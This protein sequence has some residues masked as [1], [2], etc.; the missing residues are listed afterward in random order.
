MMLSLEARLAA[1]SME[2]ASE[3]TCPFTIGFRVSELSVY[4][5]V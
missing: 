5:R 4:N 1:R 2:V 3:S